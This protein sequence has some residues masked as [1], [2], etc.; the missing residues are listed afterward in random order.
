MP[1]SA[2]PTST[3]IAIVTTFINGST[4]VRNTLRTI[5]TFIVIATFHVID[6]HSG[7]SVA[8]LSRRTLLITLTAPG[9]YALE[10]NTT[11]Q[12]LTVVID[13]AF[14]LKDAGVVDTRLP[15]SAIVIA[16]TA[17]LALVADADLTGPTL[18][19][20]ATLDLF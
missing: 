15:I 16:S 13:L 6:A 5:S 19:I 18:S 12:R 20:T 9:L 1:G 3:T 7:Q 17:G 10:P 14:A 4:L 8:N 2:K 11:K